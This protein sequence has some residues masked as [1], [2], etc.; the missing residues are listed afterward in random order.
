MCYL[1]SK[2]EQ[3][4]T[5]LCAAVSA[6]SLEVEVLLVLKTSILYDWCRQFKNG[7]VIATRC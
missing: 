4:G 2:V 1:C 7:Q 5:C 3:A 6:V